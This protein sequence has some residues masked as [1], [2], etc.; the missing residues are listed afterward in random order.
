MTETLWQPSSRC[1]LVSPDG[2]DG[3]VGGVAAGAAVGA[4]AGAAVGAAAGAAVG[5]ATGA[6]PESDVG[7]G[8]ASVG[9]RADGLGFGLFFKKNHAAT[10]AAAK[11]RHTT[12]TAPGRPI[13][14]GFVF[15]AD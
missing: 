7:V 11:R 12:N 14:L 13:H 10:A 2:G 9:G 15:V 5:A 4:T 3:A 8:G 1:V 6:V